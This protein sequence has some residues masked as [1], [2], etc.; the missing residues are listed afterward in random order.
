MVLFGV[1]LCSLGLVFLGLAALLFRRFKNIN[2]R[3]TTRYGSR[4]N[5][6]NK[7]RGDY[8]SNED[9][10]GLV[11]RVSLA[12]L[13]GL[14]CFVAGAYFVYGMN[15]RSPAVMGLDPTDIR[16]TCRPIVHTPETS[17]PGR[18]AEAAA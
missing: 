6:W 12:L 5:L 15:S 2:R 10:R 1:L 13:F 4:P 11:I 18:A 16:I 9:W 17:S 8:R 3:L 14:F 7:W